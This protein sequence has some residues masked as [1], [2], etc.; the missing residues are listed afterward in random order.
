[1]GAYPVR[2]Y[3]IVCLRAGIKNKIVVVVCLLF[4]LPITGC[5]RPYSRLE[6]G[7]GRGRGFCYKVITYSIKE[8][9]TLYAFRYV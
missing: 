7:T 3:I 1:M 6:I 8:L 9:H 5:S 2:R 4:D